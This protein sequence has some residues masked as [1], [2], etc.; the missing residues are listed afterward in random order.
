VA[1]D[2][3]TDRTAALELA[4]RGYLSD[5]IALLRP[6]A[7]ASDD[8]EDRLLLGRM[9]FLATDIQ[10]A[11]AQLERAY[12]DFQARGLPRRAAMAAT[13]LGVHFDMLDEKVVGRAW[14]ARAAPARV[15]GALGGERVR[16]RRAVR[17]HG[18]ER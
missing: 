6:L 10:D 4:S 7:E 14:L 8:P 17:R 15:R 3:E 18:R 13:W 11:R 1:A 9:A 16:A 12:R 5:A 2:L